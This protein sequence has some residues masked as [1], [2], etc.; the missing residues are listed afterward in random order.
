MDASTEQI[1]RQRVR[2]FEASGRTAPEFAGQLGVHQTT[3]F[4]YVKLFGRAARPAMATSMALARVQ[5][6]SGTAAIVPAATGDGA[7]E[8]VVGRGLVVRVRRGFDEQV[9]AAVVRVLTGEA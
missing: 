6:G 1:W 7:V 5:P 8:V 3:L 4:K 9:L 2:D